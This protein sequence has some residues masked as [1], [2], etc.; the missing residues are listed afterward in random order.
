VRRS[1]AQA[2]V[3]QSPAP[4]PVQQP[5]M[6]YLRVPSMQDLKFKKA[7]NILEI[8]D[9]PL[10]VSIF[11]A[12]TSSYQRLDIGFDLT[13]FTFNELVLILGKDNVVLK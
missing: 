11:D 5:R 6:L 13:A 9:G 12:S 7:L 1:T 4:I 3:R 8:F 2:S 10:P